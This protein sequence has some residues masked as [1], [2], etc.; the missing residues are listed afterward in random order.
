MTVAVS[1]NLS[2][3]YRL[4][5]LAWG[6]STIQEAIAIAC[7]VFRNKTIAC[8]DPYYP[9]IVDTVRM[10]GGKLKIIPEDRMFEELEKL[11]SGSLFYI[12]ADFSKPTGK[13]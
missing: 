12:C 10:V 2:I 5:L 6:F 8:L 1:F 3:Q 7:N 4:S 11:E 9:G 13:L